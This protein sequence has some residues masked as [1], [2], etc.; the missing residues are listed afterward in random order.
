MEKKEIIKVLKDQ[1]KI[2]EDQTFNFNQF[3]TFDDM[4]ETILK[5]TSVI[6]VKINKEK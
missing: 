3:R 4:T 6:E 1:I 2:A 5:N